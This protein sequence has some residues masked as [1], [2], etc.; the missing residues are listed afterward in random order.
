MAQTYTLPNGDIVKDGDEVVTEG[1]SEYTIKL[2]G[3]DWVIRHYS[4]QFGTSDYCLDE[5][6]SKLKIKI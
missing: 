5:K 2:F 1:G 6:E 4:Y 3:D